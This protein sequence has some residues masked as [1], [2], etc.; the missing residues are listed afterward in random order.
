M[1]RHPAAPRAGA[2]VPLTALMLVFL[3]GMVAFAVDLGYIAV[4]QKEMQNAADASAMAGVSQLLD[5]NALKGSPNLSQAVANAR[6]LAQS[7]SGKNTAGGVSLALS[8]NDANDGL[9]DIVCGYINNPSN[10][11]DPLLTD[12]STYNSVQTRVR[13]NSNKNG[14]LGL[15][16]GSIL[17]RSSVD[18]K[19]G[20]TATYEGNLSGFYIPPSSSATCLMLPFT[21]EVHEWTNAATDPWYD[22]T[23]PGGIMQGNGPDDWSY[24]PITQAYAA[25]GDGIHEVKLY[26]YKGNAPGNF[27]TLNLGQTDNATSILERQILNGPNAQDLSA[28]PNNTIQLGSDGTL[29]LQGNPGISAAM[30]S[31]L[32]SIRGM[33]RII[34][35]YQTVSG[36]GDNCNYVIVAFAGTTILDVNLTG[37]DKHITIQPEYVQ[38]GTSVSGGNSSTSFFVTKPLKLTR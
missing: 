20:A 25:G 19:A 5:R 3:L 10:L 35:L 16:F 32:A 18:L 11:S 33:K 15:F 7:F 31:D 30:N 24:N 1:I 28:F 23:L 26:P 36:E 27:G 17:G 22:P 2:V 8:A 29:T 12:A 21:L 4:V 13:R 6:T 14:S 34:P 37:T 9:G 38:D